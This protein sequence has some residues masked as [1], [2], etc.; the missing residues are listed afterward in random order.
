M[1]T[2]ENY[3]NSGILEL[4]VLGLTSVEETIEISKLAENSEILQDEIDTISTTLKTYSANTA[5]ELDPGI[6]GLL[7]GTIDYTERLQNGEPFCVAPTLSKDS[8]IEDF[9]TWLNIPHL[10]VY[11][12][13]DEINAKI[14][15]AS[16][17][18]MTSIIWLKNGAPIEVHDKEFEHFLILE[19]SC[20]ITIGE[21]V[22]SLIPGDYLAIPLY[23]GHSVKV[24]SD[25]PCKILL[26]RVAA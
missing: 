5:P 13:D 11:N 8:K 4:Y 26:Q 12:S 21:D 15:S 14:I 9:S 2:I 1:N 19:G 7:M 3:I 20:D 24:T 10:N 22:H 16:P 6:K 23:I 18:V 17:E 25:F